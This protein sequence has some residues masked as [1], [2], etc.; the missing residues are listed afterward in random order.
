VASDKDKETSEDSV[1]DD[2]KKDVFVDAA[3]QWSG[4]TFTYYYYYS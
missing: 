3:D 2:D 1:L 4:T